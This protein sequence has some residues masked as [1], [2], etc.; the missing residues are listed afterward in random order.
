MATSRARKE[1]GSAADTASLV[2]AAQRGDRLAFG[3]LYARYARTVHAIAVS[4]GSIQEAA[5]VVQEAFLRALRE[6]HRLR[7]VNAFGRW[8]ATIARNVV[9]DLHRLGRGRIEVDQE[10]AGRHTQHEELEARAVLHVL[11]S[12]PKA[13]REPLTMRLVEGMTGPEIANRTGL[14][15]ASVRVNLH[16]GMKLLRQ[17]LRTRRTTK[18]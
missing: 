5:D 6:L 9:L 16:R 17:R 4:R 11:G 8:I 13:Y 10:P 1:R 15:P 2:R 7:D 14:T 3:Q 18:R 12:L